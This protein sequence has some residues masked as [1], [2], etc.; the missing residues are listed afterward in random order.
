MGA[1]TSVD[2]AEVIIIVIV[3][4]VGV[5]GFMYAALKDDEKK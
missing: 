4:A 3:F 2:I 1:F 5:G